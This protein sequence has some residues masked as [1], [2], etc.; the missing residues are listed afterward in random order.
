MFRTAVAA[1]S[2]LCIWGAVLIPNSIAQEFPYLAPEAPEFDRQG[3][4][5]GSGRAEEPGTSA[6][7]PAEVAPPAKPR[8][9]NH[10][11]TLQPVPPSSSA[12]G[13]IGRSAP[14][15][16]TFGSRARSAPHR[17]TYRR[18]PTSRYAPRRR[19]PTRQTPRQY[20]GP[21]HGPPM[22]SRPGAVPGAVGQA[23]DCTQYPMMIAQARSEGEMRMVA[24]QYLTCL[25]RNGWSMAQAK[26]HV[27]S[28]IET[29]YRYIR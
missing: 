20:A 23:P 6:P 21:R 25:L 3:V 13:P 22:A 9:N 19:A 11:G 1:V 27:I 17:N 18:A 16:P 8:R 24:R 29:S 28:V 26:K 14:K 12:V 4:Y 15:A 10:A 7:A 5:V 2:L